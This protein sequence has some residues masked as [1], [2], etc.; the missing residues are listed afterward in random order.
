MCIFGRIYV[1]RPSRCHIK[2]GSVQPVSFFPHD[3]PIPS[4]KTMGKRVNM[5]QMKDPTE[6]LS[7][8]NQGHRKQGHE[9]QGHKHQ[10]NKHQGHKNQGHENQGHEKTRTRTIKDTNKQVLGN[11][12]NENQGHEKVKP[13]ESRNVCVCA[14]ASLSVRP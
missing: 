3:S 6:R 5:Y 4:W 7:M 9:N 12:G 13:S 2:G 1:G 10:G 14:P 11:Q 8:K